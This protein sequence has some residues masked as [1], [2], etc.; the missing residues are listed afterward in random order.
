MV[1]EGDH[2]RRGDIIMDG[3]RVPHDILQVLG[4]PALADYL[5]NEIQEVYRLQ[6]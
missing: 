6:V 3:H 5:I 2:V 1:Q 4:V